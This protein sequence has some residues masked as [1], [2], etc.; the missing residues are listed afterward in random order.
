[1]DRVLIEKVLR[2][3]HKSDV[4]VV[5]DRTK[6]IDWTIDDSEAAVTFAGLD[7]GAPVPW[8]HGL[9]GTS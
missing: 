7:P 2:R 4:R 8:T 9:G 3:L 6:G 5:E 1:M